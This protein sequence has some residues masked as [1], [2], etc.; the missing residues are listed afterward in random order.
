MKN[1]K[2]LNTKYLV[3][4]F[5]LLLI[6]LSS[7]DTEWIDTELNVD[8]DSPS[9][10]PMS[11]LLP[12]VQQSMGYNLLGNN[13]VRTNN[14][15]TQHFD[16]TARQSY[17][18]ARYQFTAA[19]VNNLWG[20]TYTEMFMNL[21]LIIDKS[22]IEGSESDNF[23]GVAQVLQ[24]TTLGITTDLFGDVP[25]SDA[26]KGSQNVLRPE[27]DTQERVYDTIFNI[28]D[29]AVVNLNSTTNVFA[30]DG[31]VIYG[32]SKDKWLKAAHSVKARHYLQLSNVLGNEAYTKALAEVASGFASNSDDYAVPFEDS[33]RNP[34]FQFMEQRGDIRMGATFVDMLV[35]DS[36]PR[37]EFFVEEDGDGNFV[38]SVPGSQNENASAP[39]PYI[40]DPTSSVYLMTYSE[41]KFIEAEAN[42]GL[43]NTD[44]A[45]AAYEEAVAASVLRVT[46]EANTDWLD[47]NI[48]GI[49]A[50][51]ETILGQKYIDGFG[52]NQPYADY[53]RTGFPALELAQGAI[54]NQIPVR[55]PYAQSEKDY[56]AA[57]VPNVQLTDKLW[58]DQ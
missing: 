18:E 37:T 49:P 21:Q 48:N 2:L 47:D 42:L 32:G 12:A 23:K 30:I 13:S 31:D 35:A 54:L 5:S 57:N 24:A 7:C 15:W 20:S 53:R 55:F 36:D 58:W 50:S 33:N 27:Y 9:N 43:G 25:F 40:A 41:L 52:T 44:A 28:L 22:G 39:G 8:P 26:F 10:V 34:I 19:D 56:N 38:G 4:V 46:G 1:Y 16:G 3:V 17:T 14:I 51:L 11:L 45:Q 29:Q 6:S